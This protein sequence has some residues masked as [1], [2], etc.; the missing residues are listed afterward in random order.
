MEHRF[1]TPNDGFVRAI[2]LCKQRLVGVNADDILGACLAGFPKSGP[3]GG[4]KPPP[5]PRPEPP[6][7]LAA[8]I[9]SNA[10]SSSNLRNL[11]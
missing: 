4:P 7:D 1:V 3:P 5:P 8:W 11:V 2:A 6:P 9:Q 10:I